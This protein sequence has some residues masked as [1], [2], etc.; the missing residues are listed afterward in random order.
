M[1]WKLYPATQHPKL[2]RSHHAVL[3][4]KPHAQIDHQLVLTAQQLEQLQFSQQTA[5]AWRLPSTAPCSVCDH[6]PDS[7]K[8]SFHY[9]LLSPSPPPVTASSPCSKSVK[10]NKPATADFENILLGYTAALWP[11]AAA[12]T[13]H[14]NSVLYGALSWWSLRSTEDSRKVI[15]LKAIKKQR[16]LLQWFL[17]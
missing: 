10:K 13:R 3:L 14:L 4:L 12:V 5:R 6:F 16:K 7:H 9:V 2:P 1:L 11:T 8:S 15:F 17:F